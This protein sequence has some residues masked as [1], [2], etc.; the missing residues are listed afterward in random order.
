MPSGRQISRCSPCR[1]QHHA[2]PLFRRL[3]AGLSPKVFLQF[4]LP[5]LCPVRVSVSSSLPLATMNQEPSLRKITLPVSQALMA[6]T[7]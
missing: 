6:N 3:P 7:L 1:A 5:V 4:V 2:D